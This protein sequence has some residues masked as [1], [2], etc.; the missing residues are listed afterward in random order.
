[1][2]TVRRTAGDGGTNRISAKGYVVTGQH[3]S[4]I[5]ANGEG[6]S[7]TNNITPTVFTSTGENSFGFGA[8]CDWS[9]N[10]TPASSDLTEDAADYAGAISVEDGYKDLG[11]SGAETMNFDAA[12]TGAATWNWVALEILAAADAGD[13][14]FAQGVC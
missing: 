2:P 7:T 10:G 4:P 6:S 9:A 13:T 8:A 12:G 1:M 3:A 14:L 11:A 5:G